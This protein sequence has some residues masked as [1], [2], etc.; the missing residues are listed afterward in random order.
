MRWEYDG[1][2]AVAKELRGAS[3][4]AGNGDGGELSLLQ[5][6]AQ[7]KEEVGGE[8]RAR[9]RMG[10]RWGVLARRGLTWLDRPGR[11]RRAA[12][13]RWPSPG[14]G[15]PLMASRTSHQSTAM[16]PDIAI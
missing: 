11:R 1:T 13:T 16:E 12:S 2:V 15:R 14:A 7:A 10:E 6:E 8:M 9:E 3:W 4:V 5:V